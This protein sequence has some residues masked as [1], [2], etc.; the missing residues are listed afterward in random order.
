MANNRLH[1]LALAS[2]LALLA[3]A[4]RAD[5][6]DDYL[7]SAMAERRIPGLAVGIVRD[8]RIETRFYGLANVETPAPVDE[9]SIFAIASLD[10]QLTASGLV[11]L[12]QMG[13][14][15]LDD[16][17]AKYVEGFPDG[18]RLRHLISHTSGL[19]DVV[20]G[21]IEGRSFTD[22]TTEQLLATMRNQTPVAPPGEGYLYSDANLVLAQLVTEKIAGE[23]WW[24][25]MR[26]E[27]FAPAGMTSVV[28]L[29]PSTPIPGRVAPYT[30]D[31]DG[32][33]VRDRRL[34]ID[35]GPLFCDLG[36]TTG[37]FARWLAALDTDTPLARP[38]REAMWTPVK[39]ADGQPGGE[40]FQWRRYGFGFGLDTLFGRRVVVHSGH[41]GVG[42]VKLPEERLS[43]VVF[44][45]LE[46]PA[47]S[48]PV[49]LAYGVVGLLRPDLSLAA[50]PPAAD[51]DPARG[52][53][54]RADYERFAA[55]DPDLDRY[56]PRARP[57]AWGGAG[58]LAGRMAR[59]GKLTGFHFLRE[60]RT[61][62]RVELHYR[63]DHERGSVWI[64]F[65]LDPDGR[66]ATLRW[67][68]L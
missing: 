52:A 43:V 24:D 54:L 61:E 56:A 55:G 47:G 7:R 23:P 51:P 65:L 15:S 37:D 42:M 30:L 8:G 1:R 12:V 36:M 22:Y 57:L 10:K 3:P 25:Y 28:S 63:A 50:L 26:R 40:F 53:A 11:K 21:T 45:N 68:R 35:F 13:K 4:L 66:I 32:K 46:H 60:E 14:A 9:H 64:S 67:L 62:G 17:L 16:P 31:G 41:S 19:P 49:G 5:P 58:G 2:S 38:S 34:D 39:L 20:G 18:I 27:I 44:T 59:I 6:I 33:L 29:A 48:D